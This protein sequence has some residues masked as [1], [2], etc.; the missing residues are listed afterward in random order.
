MQKDTTEIVKELGLCP[1]FKTFYNE[2][3]NYI[4][5]LIKGGMSVEEVLKWSEE[6][7]DKY[8]TYFFA[9]S[10]KFFAKSGRVS[11]F[12][13]FMG[14]LIGIKPII[15]MDDNGKLEL[16]ELKKT[17]QLRLVRPVSWTKLGEHTFL[18]QMSYS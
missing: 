13:G 5:D 4:I 18:Y 2:N 8:A 9:D 10:L 12:A 7:V 15:Y 11:G 16:A 1:D 14:N 6:N 3:K 17:E